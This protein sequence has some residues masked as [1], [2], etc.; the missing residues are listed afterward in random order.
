M[1]SNI[2]NQSKR[3]IG[4]PPPFVLKKK[5]A[6]RISLIKAHHNPLPALT[7]Q[8]VI[9]NKRRIRL[10]A[11]NPRKT[12]RRAK[13]VYAFEGGRAFDTDRGVRAGG[14]GVEEADLVVVEE[15]GG[16]GGLVG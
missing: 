16:E 4:Y 10:D 7:S 8:E 12:H 6:T 15:A 14:D 2:I 5:A 1:K 9:F 13:N 11:R 3:S